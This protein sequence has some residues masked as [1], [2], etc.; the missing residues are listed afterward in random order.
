M[1]QLCYASSLGQPHRRLRA[2]FNTLPRTHF[3]GVHHMAVVW[4]RMDRRT[5][6]AA[7]PIQVSRFS[8]RLTL[9]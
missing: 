5:H 6:N 7:R 1:S 4:S 3:T 9:L 8:V 2:A